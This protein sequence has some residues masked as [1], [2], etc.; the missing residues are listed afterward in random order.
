MLNRGLTVYPNVL[1][2]PSVSATFVLF[3]VL[4][5]FVNRLLLSI[6]LTASHFST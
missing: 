1:F 2:L 4:K 6:V 5:F 3:V